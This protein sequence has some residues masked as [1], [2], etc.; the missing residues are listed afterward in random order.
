M[1]DPSIAFVKTEEI[2][3]DENICI[4]MERYNICMYIY[5]DWER[6]EIRKANRRVTPQHKD[7]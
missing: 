7:G 4:Y 2:L 1:V 5:R 6:N 3:D